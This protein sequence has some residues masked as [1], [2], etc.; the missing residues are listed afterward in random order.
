MRRNSISRST[1][2][3]SKKEESRPL[4]SFRILPPLKSQQTLPAGCTDERTLGQQLE[5]TESGSEASEPSSH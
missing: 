3:N 2:L 1:H 4:H 5:Q